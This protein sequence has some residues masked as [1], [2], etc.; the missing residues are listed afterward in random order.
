MKKT[1][2]LSSSSHYQ[3]DQR[4]MGDTIVPP[5]SSSSSS[6]P[7]HRQQQHSKKS[8]TMSLN[9]INGAW[10]TWIYL[11]AILFRLE[12]VDAKIG[13]HYT[14][15]KPLFKNIYTLYTIQNVTQQT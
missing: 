9:G 7:T 10:I 6:Q 1:C 5:P 4:L 8:R 14:K 15:F 13:K 11:L 2:A 3:R 12:N